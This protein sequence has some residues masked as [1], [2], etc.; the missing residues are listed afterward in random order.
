MKTPIYSITET[1]ILMVL[2]MGLGILVALAIASFVFVSPLKKEAVERGYAEWQVTDNS[3]GATR[4]VWK[5]TKNLV[6]F[7]F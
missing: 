1:I 5:E 2:S 6:R 7:S 3:I 4:F